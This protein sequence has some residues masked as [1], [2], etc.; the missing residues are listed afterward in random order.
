MIFSAVGIE[1]G[2]PRDTDMFSWQTEIAAD[3]LISLLYRQVHAFSEKRRCYA[4]A[5][6]SR[7]K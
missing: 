6:E 2:N 7:F 4:A 5:N 1:S 3:I